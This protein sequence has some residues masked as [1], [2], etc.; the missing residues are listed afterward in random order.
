MHDLNRDRFEKV[1]NSLKCCG[2]VALC[3]AGH[4]AGVT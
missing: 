2:M 1:Q 3:G 4:G